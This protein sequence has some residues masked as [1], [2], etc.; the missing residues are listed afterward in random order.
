MRRELR[1]HPVQAKPARGS[2]RPVRMPRAGLPRAGGSGTATR[3]PAARLPFLQKA[4]LQEILSELKKVQ[5]PTRQETIN[6]TIV[7]IVVAA[8]LGIFLGGIDFG[9]N[10][11]IE[12]TLLR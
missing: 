11:V 12:N 7:V 9:F 3:G 5:W 4:W 2:N 6:L 8:A 10:W 1:R